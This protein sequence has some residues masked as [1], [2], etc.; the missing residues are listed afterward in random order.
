MNSKIFRIIVLELGNKTLANH[1]MLGDSWKLSSEFI[2][3]MR[4]LTSLSTIKFI[5]KIK[6]RINS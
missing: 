4:H 2:R 3:V 6:W 1:D 5:K